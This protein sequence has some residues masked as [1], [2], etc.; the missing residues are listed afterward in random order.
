MDV[1]VGRYGAFSQM[2][3]VWQYTFRGGGAS[4]MVSKLFKGKKF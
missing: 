1:A 3:P 2:A 4:C